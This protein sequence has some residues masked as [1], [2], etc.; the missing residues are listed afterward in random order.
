MFRQRGAT[1]DLADLTQDIARYW[2]RLPEET[3]ARILNDFDVDESNPTRIVVS[4]GGRD[5]D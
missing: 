1:F 2:S 5:G 3:R 4:L